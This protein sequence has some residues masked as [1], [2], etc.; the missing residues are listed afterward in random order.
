MKITIE[1]D[2]SG[3]GTYRWSLE[4]GPERIDCYTGNSNTLGDCFERIIQHRTITAM[5][6][7]NE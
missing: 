7:A 1:Q 3:V 4:T 5:E 6:Y 2:I